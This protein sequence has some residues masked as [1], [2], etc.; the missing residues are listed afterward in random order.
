MK[1]GGAVYSSVK[2]DAETAE[3]T[4]AFRM[5][6]VRDA[7]VSVSRGSSLALRA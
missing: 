4:R 5:Y 3:A 2:Q 6:F 1:A 7:N